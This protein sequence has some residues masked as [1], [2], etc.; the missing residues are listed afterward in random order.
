MNILLQLYKECNIIP[1]ELCIIIIYT[2]RTYNISNTRTSSNTTSYTN[3]CS[4]TTSDTYPSSNTTSYTNACS[5][6]PSYT[7]PSSNT[8]SYTNACS[9]T[10]SYTYPSSNT[11]TYTNS[12]WDC[13]SMSRS[14]YFRK[15]YFREPTIASEY[16]VNNIILNLIFFV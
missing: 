4:N 15:S 8:T 5:N 11:T 1:A 14:R 2:Y 16:M 7:Y 10:T 12:S 3:P 6:T 9:Y 13:G